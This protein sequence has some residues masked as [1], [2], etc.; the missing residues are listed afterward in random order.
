MDFAR[1]P[2]TNII[3]PGIKEPIRLLVDSQFFFA[4]LAL[5]YSG[6][7]AMAFLGIPASQNEVG[8]PDFIAW[9]DRYLDLNCP[10]QPTGIEWWGA[11]CGVLHTHSG[12]SRQSRGGKARLIHYVDQCDPPVRCSSES[13]ETSEQIVVV[14][15]D[16]LVSAFFKGMDQYLIHLF[17]DPKRRE[18]A[19][20]R[21]QD[22][23]VVG[24]IEGHDDA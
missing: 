14:S 17:A 5:T 7:D 15:I 12:I 1:D 9:C 20:D 2:L 19:E 24:S 10:E 4:A 6:I 8:S 11:R 16:H 21:L 22:M 3:F 13:S 23:F 18:I